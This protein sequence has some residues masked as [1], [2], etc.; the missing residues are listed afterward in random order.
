LLFAVC[1]AFFNTEAPDFAFRQ[2][3]K[4]FLKCDFH[5]FPLFFSP[6]FFLLIFERVFIDAPPKLEF[7]KTKCS[8]QHSVGPRLVCLCGP[9]HFNP[10]T[11]CSRDIETCLY[12]W[13]QASFPKTL[14]CP[15][16]LRRG[17]YPSPIPPPNS[18]LFVYG[19]RVIS[20]DPDSPSCLLGTLLKA[21]PTISFFP[22]EHNIGLKPLAP[23]LSG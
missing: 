21:A 15:S 2:T 22:I 16:P 6:P 19:W 7:R 17:I 5:N 12:F 3:F 9:L 10:F 8:P 13:F 18:Y 23:A 1:F 11:G 4:L 20:L 14:T